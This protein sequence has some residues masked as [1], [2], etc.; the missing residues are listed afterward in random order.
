METK[1]DPSATATQPLTGL[2]EAEVLARRAQGLG[3]RS[4]FPTSR[5]YRQILKENVF[6]FLN[7]VL[8]GLGIALI[9]L[10]RVSEALVSVGVIA[11]N[12]IVS[13]VQEI[14]AK[15]ILDHIALITRPSV[16]VIREGVR[17]KAD[18]GDIVAGDILVAEPG[19]QIV[20]D[21]AVMGEAEI[22][23][24]ESLLSGE[25]DPITKRPG[26]PVYSGSFCV[27]GNAYY[28]AEKVGSESLSN[29]LT[30]SARAFRRVRTPLQRQVNLV[31]RV[32][33][34]IAVYIEILLIVNTIIEKTPLV[35]GIR[36][37]VVVLGLVPNGLF[38]AIATAYGLGA[39]RIA[40]KGALVQQSNAIESLSHVDV[41]CLD[42]TGTL[43]T[44]RLKVRSLQPLNASEEDLRRALG[45]FSASFVSKN[46]T[47]LA[48]AEAYPGD[49]RRV[50]ASVPFSSN[51]RW[52]GLAFDDPDRYGVF[53]LGAPEAILPVIRGS[54]DL[55]LPVQEWA[56]QGLRVLLF[57]HDPQVVSLKGENGEPQ[58]PLGLVLWGA[59]ALADELRPEAQATIEGFRKA[60]V[61]LKL[62]SGDSPDTVAA[63]ARQAGFDPGGGAVS[64]TE[65]TG[66]APEQQGQM[67]KSRSIFGRVAPQQKEQI[68]QLLHSQGKYVAM[69]GDGINDV[70]ALKQADLAIA[71]QGGSQAARAVADIV[72]LEDSFAVLPQAVREGQRILI[73][74]QDTFKLFLTRILYSLLII[75]SAGSSGEFP[76]A[77]KHNTI[78]TLFTVGI[79]TIALVAWAKPGVV[80][81]ANAARRLAHFILPPGLTLGLVGLGV[82]VGYL[83]FPAILSGR[84]SI[85]RGLGIE[86]AGMPLNAAQSALTS[87]FIFC[88]LLLILFVEPP[89]RFWAGGDRLSRDRRPAFLVLFLFVVYG[90]ILATPFLRDFFELAPLAGWE[91]LLLIGLAGLWAIWVR[92]LWRS[93]VLNRYLSLDGGIE[94]D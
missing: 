66:L 38:L 55:T 6:T 93:R 40:R 73:G 34:L 64:G 9:L 29:R 31:V 56:R 72:L 50:A 3:N 81:R 27:V 54:D 14:R 49:P 77:P 32:L 43:T 11:I 16:T 41:L 59:I 36:M 92:W 89:A 35:E 75:L 85:T 39:V 91:Y 47:A 70:L 5:T 12:V 15:R 74:M 68:L 24:D 28:Q 33:L 20:A 60:G 51:Y 78:L 48:I 22:Q 62:I 84:F 44:N 42:K 10:G 52:S 69:I 7:N 17:K 21:G 46:R 1:S 90:V 63:L 94:T 71:M 76:L 83:L 88:G 45:D 58:L 2:S 65:L 19:D 82:F 53:V 87:F 4:V 25:S 23:V 30:A 26:D 8:F 67:V 61:E 86:E 18:L 80:P 13:V 37:S 79:P 57:A